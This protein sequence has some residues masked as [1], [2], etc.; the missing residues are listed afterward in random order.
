MRE[1]G[2]RGG[3]VSPQTRLRKTADDD[4]REQVRDTLSRALRG[5]EVPKA[6]LDAARSLFSYR[7]DAPPVE[8]G[9]DGEYG[10]ERMPDGTRPTG[11]A[12]VVNLAAELGQLDALDGL[13]EAFRNVVAA[14]EA[15]PPSSLG[16][17]F[18]PE[19][20]DTDPADASRE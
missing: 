13:V 3:K 6:A 17:P 14:A 10:G 8:R 9:L 15:T 20:R 4:L 16:V 18:S 7:A 12:D 1:L 5:E 19:H 11:L 2:R